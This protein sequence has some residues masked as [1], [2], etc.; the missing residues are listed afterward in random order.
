M[1]P[2]RDWPRRFP[3]LDVRP[4]VGDFSYPV[5]LPADLAARPKTGFFPGSTIG[6]FT[7]AEAA[8]PAARLPRRA[9]AAA[10]G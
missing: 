10:A 2:K 8:A 6:N 1:M 3:T 7:P 9:V 4:I 5:A